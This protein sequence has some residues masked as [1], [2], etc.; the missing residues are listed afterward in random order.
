VL[1]G[2][3]FTGIHIDSAIGPCCASVINEIV[4]FSGTDH[5]TIVTYRL[6]S[7]VARLIRVVYPVVAICNPWVLV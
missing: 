1:A 7:H 5:L 2:P 6:G 3:G 4:S